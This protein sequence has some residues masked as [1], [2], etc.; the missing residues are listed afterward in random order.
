MTKFMPFRK[1]NI[2]CPIKCKDYLCVDLHPKDK[3]VIESDFINFLSINPDSFVEIYSKNM[4]EHIDNIGQFLSLA[5]IALR[6][7]GILKIIT[8]NAEF[9]PFYFPIIHKFGIGAHSSN[10]YIENYKYENCAP[11]LCLYT[12]MHL[13]NLFH[14]YG[15]E[16]IVCKRITLGSRLLIIGRKI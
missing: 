12:K 4:I 14:K 7:N 2:G 16:V 1:V 15:F 3:D 5:R 11:H 6:E 8:D 10:K 9:F 13:E